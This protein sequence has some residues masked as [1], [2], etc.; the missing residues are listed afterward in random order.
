MAFNV[1]EYQTEYRK[2]NYERV[3]FDV[4]KGDR[5]RLKEYAKQQGKSINQ[6]IKDLINQDSGLD[7]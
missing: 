1:N 7:L 4:K 5:K 6:Y 2:E 3:A